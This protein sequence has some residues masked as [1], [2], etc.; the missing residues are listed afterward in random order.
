MEWTRGEYRVTDDPAAPDRDA[1][2]AFLSGSY[3]A[4][5]IDR[6][7]FSRSLDNS[8]CFTLQC[9]NRGE[10]TLAGFCRAVT[11]RATFA[12]LADVFVLPEHRG[13]GLGAWLVACVREHPDLQG[14]RRFLLATA[15][16]HGLYARFGFTPLAS[17]EAFM[18]IHTPYGAQPA[19]RN[20]SP[21]GDTDD[22]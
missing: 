20:A 14:L 1:V 21:G 13:R 5:G 18:E 16:A 19:G 8:L 9:V 15:D 3:W 6:E 12:Y 7:R 10:R 22:G 4:R 2:Y 11:D 17:A